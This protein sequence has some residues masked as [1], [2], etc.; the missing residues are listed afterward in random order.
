[1]KLIRKTKLRYTKSGNPQQ[2][3][4]F[5]CPYCQSEVERPYGN[6]LQYKSCGCARF[7]HKR[8]PGPIPARLNESKNKKARQYATLHCPNHRFCLDLAAK[9]SNQLNCY[10]CEFFEEVKNAWHG[11]V[12]HNPC[13]LDFNETTE[14]SFNC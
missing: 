14:H 6:G 5:W 11:E 4:M 2:M 13:N 1:M 9:N 3:G 8:K 7:K 12:E 10:R